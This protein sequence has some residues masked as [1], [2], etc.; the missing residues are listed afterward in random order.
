MG[1]F[2]LAFAQVIL[3]FNLT[4]GKMMLQKLDPYVLVFV[5]YIGSTLFMY[6][7]ARMSGAKLRHKDLKGDL[8]TADWTRLFGQALCGGFLF[9]AF[10]YAGLGH[11]SATSASIISAV[12]PIITA[13]M[14]FF[15]L[16][17]KLYARNWIGVALATVG[18]LVLGLDSAPPGESQVSSWFGDLMIICAMVPESY[19]SILS[20]RLFGRVTSLG[21]AVMINLFTLL[22]VTPLALPDIGTLSVLATDPNLCMLIAASSVISGSFFYLWSKGLETVN[23]GVAGLFGGLVPV[24]TALSAFFWLGEEFSAYDGA[25]LALVLIAIFV[26]TSPKKA[27]AAAPDSMESQKSITT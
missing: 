20:K 22:L 15:I 14:A 16:K 9:N 11:T 27:P 8:T 3:G 25:G 6:A 7:M 24:F 12:L 19:Y 1:Y 17:E 23:A 21:G 10:F 26:S 5:R 13:L 4:L 18:I 2:Y